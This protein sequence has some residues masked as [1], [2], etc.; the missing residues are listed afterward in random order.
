[1]AVVRAALAARE[2]RCWSDALRFQAGHLDP[3][4]GLYDFCARWYDRD[5]GRFI[6]DELTAAVT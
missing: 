3:A 5:V 2:P 6:S 4:T 1:M